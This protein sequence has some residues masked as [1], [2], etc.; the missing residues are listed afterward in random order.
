MKVKATSKGYY[1]GHIREEGETFTL[2]NPKAD[3]S[4]RWMKKLGKG[5]DV[6]EEVDDGGEETTYTPSYIDGLSKKELTALAGELDLEVQLKGKMDDRR[7]AMKEALT[8]AELLEDDEE[9]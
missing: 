9:E 7:E 6:E 4:K 5:K 3:F 1:G 2:V 8:E